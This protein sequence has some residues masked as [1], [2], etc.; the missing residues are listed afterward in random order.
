MPYI[1]AINSTFMNIGVLWDTIGMA[2]YVPPI[3]NLVILGAAVHFLVLV[4]LESLERF[5]QIQ[6]P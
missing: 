2:D 4:A 5:A 3:T 6:P 1:H